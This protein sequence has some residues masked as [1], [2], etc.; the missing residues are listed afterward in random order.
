M[1]RI[2]AEELVP[3]PKGVFV[4]ADRVRSA[5]MSKLATFCGAVS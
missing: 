1:A 5:C 3:L 2:T 4:L